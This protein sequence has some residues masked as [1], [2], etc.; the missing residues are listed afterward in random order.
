VSAR[1]TIH[2]NI[3]TTARI[4]ARFGVVPLVA[5]AALLWAVPAA[6]QDA[7]VRPVQSAWEN[8]RLVM[9][10]D[11]SAET[12][13]VGAPAVELPAVELSAV[14]APAVELPAVGAPAV[15]LPAVGA[16]TP[17]QA[18]ANFSR[19]VDQLILARDAEGIANLESVALI[20]SKRAREVMAR[21][22]HDKADL[23][24]GAAIR[25]APDSPEGY[26]VRSSVDWERGRY[27]PAL[28]WFLKGSV[29]GMH[30]YFVGMA[31]MAYL[32]VVMWLAAATALLVLLVPG[33]VRTIKVVEHRGREVT[34][35]GLPS[36]LLVAGCLALL[37]LPVAAGEGVGWVVLVW[38]GFTWLGDSSRERKAQ[39]ALLLAILLGPFVLS[40]LIAMTA[41]RAGIVGAAL[42]ESGGAFP[43][44]L[45][46]P[47]GPQ[48]GT[49]PDNW[50]VP[51]AM[52]NQALRES[53][54][55]DAVHWYDEARRMGGDTVRITNNMGVT[56]FRAGREQDSAVLFKQAADV[57][58]APAEA[59]FN[60]AK[61]QAQ[62]LDFSAQRETFATAQL[63]DPEGFARVTRGAEPQGA[64]FVYT[65]G[66][67]GN[68]ARLLMVTET[69]GWHRFMA[70]LWRSLFGPV[71]PLLAAPALLLVAVLMFMFA[72]RAFV[73]SEV[74]D[75]DVCG[76]STCHA[77]MKFGQSMHLCVRCSGKLA[78]TAGRPE[79]VTALKGQFNRTT[80][81]V[82]K[83]AMLLIPGSRELV[84]GRYTIAGAHL[85]VVAF[86]LWW[87]A[88]L[89][90][91]PNWALGVTLPGWPVARLVAAALLLFYLALAFLLLRLL[92]KRYERGRHGRPVLA[93]AA[94]QISSG[95]GE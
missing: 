35:F 8:L 41:P 17:E 12:P 13:A 90:T 64:R 70:P 71:V 19:A 43:A 21:G 58:G 92:A 44:P 85:F 7:Q 40:P 75:C 2:T 14:G 47:N 73:G 82:G 54:Y 84:Q 46:V 81:R 49:T 16:L 77:C 87:I 39:M 1:V 88:L 6:A 69:R 89:G 95:K 9:Q 48:A 80:N 76:V 86:G 24:A 34:R 50:L 32:A 83:V 28:D 74:Y 26:L 55:V 79:D 63:R 25:V 27:A 33:I 18:T 42:A 56:Y 51:F 38:T 66:T 62:N 36:W 29:T 22:A 53:R 57:P 65:L 60:L 72:P 10:A 67:T 31:W 5:L 3:R 94:A 11:L 68:E 52:G 23:Y 45:S 91:I 59:L 15:E 93:A 4:A 30:H 61:V 20:L 37:A 78:E